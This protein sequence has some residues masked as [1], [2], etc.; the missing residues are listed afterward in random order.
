MLITKIKNL[1][2]QLVLY[3]RYI[4]NAQLILTGELNL[5]LK[6]PTHPVSETFAMITEQFGLTQHVAEPTH[7][8]GGWLDVIVTRNDCQVTDVTVHPPILSDHG[9]VMASIP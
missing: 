9:L 1:V 5:Q 4:A 2:F 3:T 8:L 7:K 6:D